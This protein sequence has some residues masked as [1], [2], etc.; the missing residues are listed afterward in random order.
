MSGTYN[1]LSNGS[2]G[3][4]LS[5]TEL[6]CSTLGFLIA[7]KFPAECLCMCLSLSS[8]DGDMPVLS[9]SSSSN[10]AKGKEKNYKLYSIAINHKTG[11][12]MGLGVLKVSS[13]LAISDFASPGE[14]YHSRTPILGILYGH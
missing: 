8:L 2:E 9:S 5:P 11:R 4:I 6:M 14:Q 3:S 7:F 1:W 10:W 13:H 12:H